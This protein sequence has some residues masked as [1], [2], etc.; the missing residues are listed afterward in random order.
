MHVAGKKGGSAW[1]PHVHVV[2][3]GV[4]VGGYL[5][6]LVLAW[7]RKLWRVR[8][9]QVWRALGCKDAAAVIGVYAHRVGRQYDPGKVRSTIGYQVGPRARLLLDDA[10]AW[11][12]VESAEL[13]ATLDNLRLD[14]WWRR[15]G[16]DPFKRPD[17][18]GLSPHG[19][20][21]SR[22]I[23]G[24]WV[25]SRADLDAAEVVYVR[26]RH[27]LLSIGASSAAIDAWIA[28][29]R[30][31]WSP[32]KEPMRVAAWR[33]ETS[34]AARGSG[35]VVADLPWGLKSR[36]KRETLNPLAIRSG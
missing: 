25:P 24:A 7:A 18:A 14:R 9:S 15:P 8:L 6:P 5:D 16:S 12:P 22:P 11:G 2:A 10:R 19:L 23:S 32:P 26:G 20:P 34:R 29:G 21:W 35:R 1:Q 33:P 3:W 17:P 28:A 27:G 4:G 31:M 30:P 36:R 13:A